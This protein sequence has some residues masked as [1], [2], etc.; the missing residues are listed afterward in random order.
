MNT[1]KAKFDS[2]V[3]TLALTCAALACFGCEQEADYTGVNSPLGEIFYCQHD[4]EEVSSVHEMDGFREEVSGDIAYQSDIDSDY[5]YDMGEEYGHRTLTLMFKEDG[6]A[7]ICP[8]MWE[9][10]PGFAEVHYC[11]YGKFLLTGAV[12]EEESDE[13]GS[14]ESVVYGEINR[15][16]AVAWWQFGG[17]SDMGMLLPGT[18]W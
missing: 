18:G 4:Y 7:N 8:N 12:Y 5:R 13:I 2:V 11:H 16:Y 9:S 6:S 1:L 10:C 3:K 15:D 14:V 17:E